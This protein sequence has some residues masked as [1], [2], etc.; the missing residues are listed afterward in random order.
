MDRT[1]TTGTSEEAS[2]LTFAFVVLQAIRL[3]Q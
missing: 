1:Q 2:L 3:L